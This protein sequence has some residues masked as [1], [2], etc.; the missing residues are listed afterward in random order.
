MT[1]LTAVKLLDAKLKKVIPEFNWVR[2]EVFLTI[3]PNNDIKKVTISYN[4][5]KPYVRRNATLII[6]C[7]GNW[8]LVIGDK[9]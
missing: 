1:V 3:G 8:D 4:L 6:E 9:L 5:I 7:D 2:K